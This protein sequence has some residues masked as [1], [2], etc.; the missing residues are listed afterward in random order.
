MNELIENT[1]SEESS[2]SNYTRTLSYKDIVTYYS[3]QHFMMGTY[4]TPE[5]VT[6]FFRISI[7]ELKAYG[8]NISH[9]LDKQ[10]FPP[11]ELFS[12]EIPK[13]EKL[14]PVDLLDPEFVVAVS[15][16]CDSMDKRSRAAKLKAIG[17]SQQKFKTLLRKKNHKEFYN[18][19]ISDA[20]GEFDEVAKMAL[21]RNADSGDLQ[22]IKY[23]YELTNTYRP[24]QELLL[25]LGVIIG[26]FM[27][28]LSPYLTKDQLL[29]IADK[30][31]GVINISESQVKELE[32][33]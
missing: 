8:T 19:S 12:S 32:S 15:L 29:E 14:K 31:E 4:P 23:I 25:N 17:M 5:E 28:I 30:F 33:A 7:S 24:N 18:K 20:W 26:K 27:E 22:S 10:G 16:I 2:K 3:T 13:T 9:A 6:E 1:S 11:V 21:L